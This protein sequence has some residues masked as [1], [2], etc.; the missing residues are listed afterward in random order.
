M[1]QDDVMGKLSIV[2]TP[3]G[4]LED[5][6]LRALR[7]LREAQTVLAEDTRRTRILLNHH[8]IR[9]PLRS[10]H[11]HSGPQAIEQCVTE[12]LAGAHLALVTDA[13]TPIVSD[14]GAPL[15]AAAAE[16]S[17]T[18]EAIPGPSAVTAAL[19]VSAIACD[20]FRF[21]GFLPRTGKSRRAAL[22][23]IAAS[24]VASV[25]FESPQRIARTLGDLAEL[26]GPSREAAVCREL[27]KLHE[28]VAR[29]DLSTLQARFAQ[30][31]R[32]E[33]TLV[34]AAADPRDEEGLVDADARAQELLADGESPRD[35]ARKLAQETGM[36][37]REAY[38]L[39]QALG[40]RD[41]EF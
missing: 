23:Q 17:I 39:I 8:D 16:R 32:G 28:E 5:I 15:V 27:T 38:A 20:G 37:K 35:A 14:P 9:T 10:L 18:I 33:I 3:I 29:G 1:S 13:G 36:P 12:L 26:A 7:T 24:E 40:Q 11:A 2:A 31:A 41:D 30:N 22:A 6:T 34:V 19:T 4:N 25:V 21:F